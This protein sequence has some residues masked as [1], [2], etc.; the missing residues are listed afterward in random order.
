VVVKS[1][2]PFLC[3]YYVTSR[4]YYLCMSLLAKVV[5]LLVMS[6]VWALGFCP[7][8]GKVDEYFHLPSHI[9]LITSIL[10]RSGASLGHE[11]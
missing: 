2:V 7:F 5:H 6:L 10:L 9:D 3:F 1:G 8:K 4:L 11:L